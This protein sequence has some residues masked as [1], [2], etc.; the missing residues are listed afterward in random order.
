MKSVTKTIRKG[1]KVQDLWFS[2]EA[3]YSNTLTH[4]T[5]EEEQKTIL[6]IVTELSNGYEVVTKGTKIGVIGVIGVPIKNDESDNLYSKIYSEINNC[7]GM[8]EWAISAGTGAFYKL[9]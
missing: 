5:S 7:V 3:L 6:E 9:S 2:S 8:G 4:K 1:T